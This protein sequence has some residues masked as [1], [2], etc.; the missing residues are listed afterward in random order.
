M[1]EPEINLDPAFSGGDDEAGEPQVPRRVSDE[2]ELRPRLEDESPQEPAG[3][4]EAASTGHPVRDRLLARIAE[5]RHVEVNAEQANSV[6]PGEVRFGSLDDEL[7]RI[8]SRG[9]PPAS[10]AL[11]RARPELSP[12][13]IAMFGTLFGLAFVGAL[14][15]ILIHAD[16]RDGAPLAVAPAAT[17]A[18]APAAAVPAPALP[19][20]TV[21]KPARKRIPGPW[22]IAD[23]TDATLKKVE[24]T[25]GHEPFL[26]AIESAGVPHAQTFRVLATLKGLRDLDHCG[27]SDQFVALVDRAQ[28][29]VVAYEY[30]VSKEEVYQAREGSD[31]F[32]KA[33]KLDLEVERSRVQGAIRFDRPTFAASIEAGGF[34][35]ALA[36]V[37]D[38]ALEGHSTVA[39]FRRGDRLRVVLQETTVLGEFERYAGIEALEYL[40]AHGDTKPT[41][42]Y[43]FRGTKSHGYYDAQGRSVHEG[44]WHKPIKGAPITSPFNPHR[45]HP[46]LHKIMPHEGTDFGAPMGTPVGAA[47]PGVVEFIGNGGPTGNLVRIQHTGGIE[48]GYAH[49]SRFETGLKVGD[50]VN[51][52]QIIGYVGS[53]GRSTG[54]HLHLSVKK[55]GVFVDSEILKLDALHVLPL[56]ERAEFAEARQKLDALL[57]AVPLS[58]P[59]DE[60]APA[61]T[62]SAPAEVPGDD[63]GSNDPNV[64]AHEAAPASPSAA[65]APVTQASPVP[66]PAVPTS[67][68]KAPSEPGKGPSIYVS[69]QD[70][71][72]NQG[73]TD[74]GE[75]DE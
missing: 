75:V 4:P 47:G 66:A 18:A 48:T 5:S 58:P 37:L 42:I 63:L 8:A 10:P 3:R 49:L 54:P 31:G 46:I 44:G 43:Y 32:L 60:P 51:A 21:P 11:A 65:A 72:K 2:A 7:D 36:S 52:L 38:D 39:D 35:P 27:H 59:L 12:N 67:P 40:P 68:T 56:E 34:E 6:G 69:D 25:I 9:E 1:D 16:P 64:A 62:P 53:T 30:I 13:L 73:A 41:R 22:R 19:A 26:T 29:R 55:N 24:G 20:P 70:L 28:G 61:A 33:S 74:Q 15:A 45:M 23:S 14:F 50:H 57:D 17:S 71:L